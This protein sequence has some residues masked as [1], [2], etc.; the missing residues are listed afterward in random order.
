M[1]R[2]NDL[3]ST[4][5]SISNLYIYSCAFVSEV[6]VYYL[7]IFTKSSYTVSPFLYEDFMRRLLR[8]IGIN[9]EELSLR[10]ASFVLT[11]F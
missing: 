1:L 7:N 2:E 8:T 10:V 11:K 4:I 9:L 5:F 3:F 6:N